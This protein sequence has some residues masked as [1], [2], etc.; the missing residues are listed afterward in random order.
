MQ[1]EARFIESSET[2]F[3]RHR[4]LWPH[5]ASPELC[6]ID[7]DNRE[8]AF[9]VGVFD[10]ETLISIGSF[11]QI[12]SP[13]L[14]QQPQYRLRAMATDPDYRR[15]HAGEQLISFAC[16]ELSKRGIPVLWCDARLVAVPFYESIG[17]SKFDDV[18]EVP[19]IGPHH[20]MWKEL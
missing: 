16:E 8:D 18:Y 9:H 13:R 5:L 2:R 6:V 3:L 7:I 10:G 11:F 12:S 14:I 19:L 15:M 20:F 1:L 4:V 17:F